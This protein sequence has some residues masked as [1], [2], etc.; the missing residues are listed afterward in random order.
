MLSVEYQASCESPELF[1]FFDPSFLIFFCPR[2]PAF[3]SISPKPANSFF[4][5]SKPAPPPSNRSDFEFSVTELVLFL[6]KVD[7]PRPLFDQFRQPR[8]ISFAPTFG[9]DD[10]PS[11]VSRRN[12]IDATIVGCPN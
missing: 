1:S 6:L 8:R 9:L 4:N 10:D 3:F 5:S 2:G 7:S 12:K 11:I